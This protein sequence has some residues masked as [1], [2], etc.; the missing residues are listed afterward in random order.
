MF[1][2]MVNLIWLCK[3]SVIKVLYLICLFIKKAQD[4][5]LMLQSCIVFCYMAGSMSGQ[6]EVNPVFW[7]AN[8]VG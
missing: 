1:Q 2:K 3:N 8:Q 7:L 4:H 5:N 6:D